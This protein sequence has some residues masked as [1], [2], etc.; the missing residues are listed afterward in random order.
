MAFFTFAAFI[1]FLALVEPFGRPPLFRGGMAIWFDM[2]GRP[3]ILLLSRGGLLGGG[4]LAD[5]K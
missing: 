4:D 3:S 2:V 5:A 1:C